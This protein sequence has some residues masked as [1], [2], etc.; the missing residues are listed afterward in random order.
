[1][2]GRGRTSQCSLSF[3]IADA[4]AGLEQ[5]NNVGIRPCDEVERSAGGWYRWRS[6]SRAIDVGEVLRGD[7]FALALRHDR[8]VL[9]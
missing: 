4:D 9:I 7:P 6:G 3:R 8:R 5:N 2:P 1:M